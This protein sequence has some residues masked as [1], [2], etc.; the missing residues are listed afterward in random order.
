MARAL[1]TS[2]KNYSTTKRELLAI[3]FALKKFHPFLWGNPFTLYTDHKALTYIHT[4][5][6]ANSMMIQWLDTILDYDFKII[7]RPGIQ[8]VLPDML[9]RLFESER[10]L[11]GDKNQHKTWI[12]PQVA[13]SKNTN[14]TTRMMMPD[15]LDTEAHKQWLP[16]YTVKES[17]GQT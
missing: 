13:N 14:M 9:S 2:E 1:S 11:V 10:T 12:T 6:V 15:D 7:H 3:V 16:L 8:N 4:Q 17:I 5:P